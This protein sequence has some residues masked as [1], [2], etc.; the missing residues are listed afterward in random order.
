MTARTEPAPSRRRWV[1]ARFEAPAVVSERL[2]L[3]H[4]VLEQPVDDPA[5]LLDATE[6]LLERGDPGELWLLLAVVGAVLPDAATVRRTARAVRA[7]GANRTLRDLLRSV[8][9]GRSVEVVTDQVLVDVT[10]TSTVSFATGIQRVA[11]ETSRRWQRHHPIFVGWQR[12]RPALRRLSSPEQE[13][14]LH[15]GPPVAVAEDDNVLVPWRCHY[16]LVE[17][18]VEPRLMSQ[19]QAIAEISPNR[20]ACIGFDCVPLTT[21]ETVA[22]DSVSN[23]FARHLAAAA[24][25]DRVAT[26]SR[27]AEV[28]YAGWRAMLA[29]TGLA[30]PRLTTVLLPSDRTLPNGADGPAEPG[31]R[32]GDAARREAAGAYVLSGLP[33]VLV[34]GSHEPRKNH[35]AVLHAAERLWREGQVFSLLFVGGNGWRSE[36]FLAEVNELQSRRRPIQVV[37]AVP[38]AT[39]WALYELAYCTVFP[40]LN[41]GFGLP[42]AESLAAGTPVITSRYGSMAEIAEAGGGA[43]LVDPRDDD[44]LAAGLRTMLTDPSLYEGLCREATA[45]PVRTWDDYADDVWWYF[46]SDAAPP[47]QRPSPASG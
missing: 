25:M 26:I 24:H 21:G 29:G 19:L 27:A 33:M 45:R 39:L 9:D 3:V 37:E 17:L 32:A 7:D 16:L 11:R 8:T 22:A 28:E 35:L 4:A 5:D 43:L 23:G 31:D 34:V 6:D 14:A 38:D 40:S 30:G 13:R 46:V 15:G 42:V 47:A 1:P 44:G 10:N 20:T 2:A 18:Q 36:D 12:E 41:E